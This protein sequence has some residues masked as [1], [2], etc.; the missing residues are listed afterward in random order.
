MSPISF[1]TLREGLPSCPSDLMLDR[2][3]QDA[4]LPSESAAASAHVDRCEHCT[5]R[6]VSRR[7]GFA[8]F[9]EVDERKMLAAIRRRLAEPAAPEHLIARLG[10]FFTA[11]M[12]V[13]ATAGVLCALIV[14]GVLRHGPPRHAADDKLLMLDGVRTKGGPTLHVYRQREGGAEEMMS[15]DRFQKG[16]HLRFA[17]DLPEDGYV[18]IVG[19]DGRGA[20]YT[21][22]PLVDEAPPHPAE[23]LAPLAQQERPLQAGKRQTLPGAVMLDESP[24]D[25]QLYLVLCPVQVGPPVCRSLGK[26]QKPSCLAGC[27]LSRFVISKGP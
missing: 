17:V 15:G 26:G 7:A 4:L 19:V 24:G 21:A 25:E 14:I 5:A 27:T 18:H 12:Q 1:D 23:K 3:A 16:D 20:L 2:L 10:A 6:L 11:R 9:P 8:A 22:W 13:F